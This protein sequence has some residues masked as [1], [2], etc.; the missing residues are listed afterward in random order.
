MSL[1]ALIPARG[2]SK[3]IPKKNIRD[4]C[5]Q[6]LI[7]WSIEVALQAAE[8]DR[9][10]VS[11]DDQEIADISLVFG[12]EVP[13]LRPDRFATDETPGIEPVLHAISALPQFDWILVLQPTS[14]LRALKDIENIVNYAKLNNVKSAVSV[15]EASNHPHWTY[16]RDQSGKLS[17]MTSGVP[18]TRRQELPPAYALNGALYLAQCDWLLENKTFLSN[19]TFGYVMPL[20][21][22]VDIDSPLDW[23]WA[24]FLMRM[25]DH[26]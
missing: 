17:S 5:G 7:A 3:S 22:S 12:A 2:G 23:K 26:G 24:E 8:V 21:R 13:F 10:I 20:E 18:A 1:V 19:E 25:R 15:V 11:T 14:P 6:P 9:V 16:L 4:F